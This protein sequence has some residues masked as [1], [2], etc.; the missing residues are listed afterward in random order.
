MVNCGR[1]REQFRS[2][3]GSGNDLD[4][5]LKQYFKARFPFPPFSFANSNHQLLKAVRKKKTPFMPSL[6]HWQEHDPVGV[7]EYT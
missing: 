4:G 6:K 3:L 5:F 1:W 7:L 2:N